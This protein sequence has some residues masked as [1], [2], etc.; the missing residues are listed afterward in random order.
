VDEMKG[1]RS[2]AQSLGEEKKA[3]R[4]YTA[5]AK[6]ASGGLKRVYRHNLGEER[7]HA[8]ALRPYVGKGK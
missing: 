7:E 5:R 8:R 1:K 2:A 3:I 4:A 6:S